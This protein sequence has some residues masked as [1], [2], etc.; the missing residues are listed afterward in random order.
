VARF[1]KKGLVQLYFRLKLLFNVLCLHQ[2]L[3]SPSLSGQDYY[4]QKLFIV[5]LFYTS[6][7]ALFGTFAAHFAFD[8]QLRHPR[9]INHGHQKYIPSNIAINF[10][11]PTSTNIGSM[12]KCG[13]NE[14][15]QKLLWQKSRDC[16]SPSSVIL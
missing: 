10:D 3:E 7:F 16:N 2:R 6:G 8:Q 15:N 9:Q 4:I 5:S 11:R 12:S 13:Q 14:R 1:H